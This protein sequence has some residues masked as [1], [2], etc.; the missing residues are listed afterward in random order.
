MEAADVEKPWFGVDAGGRGAKRR[1]DDLTERCGLDPRNGQ[2]RFLSGFYGG[3]C[4]GQTEPSPTWSPV[5]GSDPTQSFYVDAT[6]PVI[7]D[8]RYYVPSVPYYQVL[9]G[10]VPDRLE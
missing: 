3:R 5:Y 4:I 8:P 7:T 1:T 9:G 10:Q 2:V 6:Y